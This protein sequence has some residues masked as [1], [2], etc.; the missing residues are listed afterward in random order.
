[1]SLF[2]KLSAEQKKTYIFIGGAGCMVLGL[3]IYGLYTHRPQPNDTYSKTL[4]SNTALE[5][6]VLFGGDVYWGRHMNDWSQAS[7]LKEAYPFS[8]LHELN[9]DKY[10]AWV[11]NLEC[12]AI[13]GI[14]QPI[15]FVP[16][17]WEFNCD[18]DYL[19]EAAKWFTAVSLGNNHIANQKREI[20]QETTRKTLDEY[21]IQHFGGF[22][23]HNK[24][25]VCNVISLPARARINGEQKDVQLPVAMC[26]YHGVYYTVTDSAIAEIQKYAKYMPVISYPHMGREYQA[27][28]DDKRR[29]LYQKMIDNGADAVLGNHPHW[30]QPVEEYK[31]KPIFYSMGNFIFDQQFSPEVMRAAT[32]DVRFTLDE[33]AATSEQLQAWIDLGQRCVQDNDDCLAIAEQQQLTKLP[34]HLSFDIISLDLSNQITKKADMRL[35]EEV[36]TRLNWHEIKT[37]LR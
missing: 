25:D 26:G 27:T 21:G 7:P 36:L 14:K 1:M 18:T 31:G 32:V 13:P 19:K 20:G 22:N 28:A 16:E 6:R 5:S 2:K 10:D 12:P 29:I 35:H 30:V 37:K 9:R 24:D 15:G 4:S 11:V 34:I 8:R 33:G 23:P 17:L 3:I